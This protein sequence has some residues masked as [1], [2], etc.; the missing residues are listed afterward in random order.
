[1]KKFIGITFIFVLF[2]GS[3]TQIK[4]EWLKDQQG[5][6]TYYEN[7][8]NQLVYENKNLVV[9]PTELP[10]YYQ[11]DARWGDKR[12][13]ISNMKIT[14]CVP[15]SLAMVISGLVKDVTPVQVADYIYDTSMEMNMT[16]SGTSSFG[17][18]IA[19]EYW[20][21]NY[22]TINSKEDLETALKKGDVVYGAVGHGIFVR[23]YSTHAVVLSGYQNGKAHAVDPDNPER[24]NK[25]YSIDDIWNQ[26]SVAPEDNVTGGAFIVVSK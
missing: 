6:W 23:G 17:A 22:R 8:S 21:L 15:T 20:D 13:G 24:T 1:M 19:L 25:W 12:Y 11:A 5:K 14:G 18:E 10:Q 16:F 9:Q 3:A 4:A 7:I 2:F 26:R